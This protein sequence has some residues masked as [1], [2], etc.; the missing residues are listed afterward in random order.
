M[1]INSVGDVAED[2]RAAALADVGALL[3]A[4]PELLQPGYLMHL[5]NGLSDQAGLRCLCCMPDSA[6]P[7]MWDV[8]SWQAGH[9]CQG[10]SSSSSSSSGPPWQSCAAWGKWVCSWPQVTQ[11]Q[12]Q[13]LR[14]A[15]APRLATCACAGCKRQSGS[16]CNRMPWQ[17]C[18][19][20]WMPG[21]NEAGHEAPRKAS[22]EAAMPCTA[23]G[24]PRSRLQGAGVRAAAVDA[25]AELCSLEEAGALLGRITQRHAQ[26][27]R[28]LVCDV[29]EGVSVRAVSLLGLLVERGHM[30]AD[31]ARP[32]GGARC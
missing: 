1:F 20:W 8:R 10:C 32:A 6:R 29:D 13:R 25:L 30:E 14:K 3:A 27:L 28:E 2:I 5:T 19:A 16:S 11:R 24:Q 12:A 26:R 23:R 4:D 15:H 22:E 17:R 18:A 31:E 7:A 21:H 9:Q